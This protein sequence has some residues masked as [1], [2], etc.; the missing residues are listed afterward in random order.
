MPR[1]RVQAFLLG[2]ALFVK[3]KHLRLREAVALASADPRRI[4]SQLSE[5]FVKIVSSERADAF[6]SDYALFALIQLDQRGIKGSPSQVVHEDLAL[7]F[8][9]S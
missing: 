2:T 1:V 9:L 3:V 8:F 5:D 6:R 4:E 7:G